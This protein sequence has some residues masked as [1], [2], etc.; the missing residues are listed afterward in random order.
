MIDDP[1]PAG[2]ATHL[3]LTHTKLAE[4]QKRLERVLAAMGPAGDGP[5]LLVVGSIH[6]N[7]PAGYLASQRVVF[8]LTNRRQDLRGRVVFL[9]GNRRALADRIRYVDRDLNRA[10][11]HERVALLRTGVSG[12]DH[13][14]TEQLELLHEID[15]V[16]EAAKGPVHLLDLHT[17]SGSG[18]AFSA[19]SDSLA[20]R[21]IAL[22][23]PVPLV[24]GLEELVDGTLHDYLGSRGALTL[25]F[26]SGQ[27]DEPRA[28][29]RAEAAIWIMLAATG[30]APEGGYP[31]MATS[32][33]LLWQD[34]RTLP[35]VFEMR[36][37]HPVLPGD[38]FVMREGFRNFQPITSGEALADDRGGPV[39]APEDARLLM[40][41]YQAQGTDGFFVVREFRPFWLHLSRALRVL[42]LN[43]IVHW[44]PGVRRHPDR[45]GAYL[46]NK[47]VARWYA[48]QLLHLLGF[49]KYKEAGDFLI[50]L[51]RHHDD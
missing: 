28:V 30:I 1:R 22:Q 39:H 37:R 26:E 31:E 3:A 29:D 34:T 50:L 23:I 10:W 48:L 49:R 33:K 21:A 5:T 4:E 40:P 20:N 46:V 17:T 12:D 32:R 42:R 45:P 14:D 36:Y 18:G 19:V 13:E 24:L 35:R 41:L 8:A 43:R 47:R 38:D 15:A 7:E 27:H 2:E 44:A 9:V 6:G 51:E 11:T 16:L 25:A